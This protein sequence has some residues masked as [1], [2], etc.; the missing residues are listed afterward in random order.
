MRLLLLLLLV[1]SVLCGD[2]GSQNNNANPRYVL[3]VAHS[4][5]NVNNYAVNDK[6]LFVYRTRDITQFSKEFKSSTGVGPHCN[7]L[8]DSGVRF[9]YVSSVD[10]A[11]RTGMPCQIDCLSIINYDNRNTT[12]FESSPSAKRYYSYGAHAGIGCFDPSNHNVDD[13]STAVDICT[14]IN[15]HVLKPKFKMLKRRE[16]IQLLS[17]CHGV[18]T[19]AT[20]LS[21]S[22]PSYQPIWDAMVNSKSTV[23]SRRKTLEFLHTDLNF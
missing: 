14:L 23:K 20:L 4:M 16:L 9:G 22:T 2:P 18:S 15:G 19:K 3:G 12:L 1:V 17:G 8:R 5:T 13:L 21:I 10:R 6:S 7:N 11:H